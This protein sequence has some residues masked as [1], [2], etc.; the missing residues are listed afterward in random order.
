MVIHTGTDTKM[1][2][3]LGSYKFKM[4]RFEK[5]LNA[6]LIGN[7]LLA[8]VLDML[9]VSLFRSWTLSTL[10][11]RSHMYL[12]QLLKQPGQTTIPL[13]T[14]SLK[15]FMSVYLIVNQFIPLDL[16]VA[17]EI[18]K[19]VYT[20]IMEGDVEMMIED[21]DIRDVSGFR[22]NHLGLHEELS[23]VDYVFCDKTGT[24][25]KNEMV[26]R[27]L[28]THEGNVF[29]CNEEKAVENLKHVLE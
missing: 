5:V 9:N 13:T 6:I 23:L 28:C 19:L 18:S 12:W 3:N 10:G 20:G 24:L 16:L 26:F 21:Y 8:L 17:L 14:L 15:N 2:M 7:L 27:G 25:T 11:E 1:T 29:W 22:A 4:S